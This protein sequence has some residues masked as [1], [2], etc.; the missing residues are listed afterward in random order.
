MVLV[1]LR[2]WCPNFLTQHQEEI[3]QGSIMCGKKWKNLTYLGRRYYAERKCKIILGA[4]IV[5]KDVKYWVGI[6][7][8]Q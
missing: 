1:I 5:R 7:G 3:F 8:V 2:D 4:R 6:F